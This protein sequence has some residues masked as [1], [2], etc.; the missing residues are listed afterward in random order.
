[1]AK[2]LPTETIGVVRSIR[3]TRETNGRSSWIDRPHWGEVG[4]GQKTASGRTF[5]R[6][7]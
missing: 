5:P 7:L 3:G 2:Q 4:F 6:V 1:M